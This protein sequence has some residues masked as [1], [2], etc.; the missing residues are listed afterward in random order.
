MSVVAAGNAFVP[1]C[2]RVFSQESASVL[3]VEAVSVLVV[4]TESVVLK[5]ENVSD[6]SLLVVVFLYC[7]QEAAARRQPRPT[8]SWP[9]FPY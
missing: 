4:S 1:E 2:V 9:D 7:Y 6:C 8:R 5:E 3:V